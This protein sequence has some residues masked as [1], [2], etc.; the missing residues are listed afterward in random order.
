MADVKFGYLDKAGAWHPVT[1]LEEDEYPTYYHRER[2]DARERAGGEPPTTGAAPGSEGDVSV[3]VQPVPDPALL[4]GHREFQENQR[5]V[6]FRTLLGPYLR[7]A[8]TITITDP[9]IRQFHQV[10]NLME[11]I[12]AVA[13]IKDPA[14][15]VTISLVTTENTE[16]EDKRQKQREFLLKA[17]QGAMALWTPE[18][19]PPAWK[20]IRSRGTLNLT[21]WLAPKGAYVSKDR[22]AARSFSFSTVAGRERRRRRPSWPHRL[23]AFWPGPAR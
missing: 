15:E 12:E 3:V 23:D 21:F 17:Q 14:E 2:G 4:E 19:H 20:S 6:S 8:R 9:Y 11:L 22:V 5:G 13:G 16:A 18:V 10:R 1:T 7:A